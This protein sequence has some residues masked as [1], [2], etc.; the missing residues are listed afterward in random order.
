MTGVSLILQY[1]PFMERGAMT[2][3]SLPFPRVA[4]LLALAAL[5]AGPVRV[6]AQPTLRSAVPRATVR[7]SEACTAA[8]G[9]LPEIRSSGA[10]L[11]GSLTMAP[12][13]YQLGG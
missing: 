1:T 13:T 5:A 6:A 11:R 12:D 9:E 7:M 8:P 2:H 10:V 4:V 3:R